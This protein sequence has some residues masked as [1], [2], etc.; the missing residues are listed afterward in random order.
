MAAEAHDACCRNALTDSVGPLWLLMIRT[1]I[2]HGPQANPS[3][4]PWRLMLMM[5]A[6]PTMAADNHDAFEVVP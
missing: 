1:L 3:S 4:T 2:A 5:L 6:A